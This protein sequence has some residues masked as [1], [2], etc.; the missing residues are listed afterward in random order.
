MVEAQIKQCPLTPSP[1]NGC[2]DTGICLSYECP[3]LLCHWFVPKILS[4]FMIFSYLKKTSPFLI[5]I[6]WEA[7]REK[8]LLIFRHCLK[9]GGER[10]NPNPNCLRHFLADPGKARGCPTNTSVTHSFVH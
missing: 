1:N 10:S 4:N 6:G 9:G 8:N 5:S 2:Y 3:V 7:R